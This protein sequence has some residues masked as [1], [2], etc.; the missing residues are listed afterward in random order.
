MK[1]RTT[2]KAF[3]KLVT[4]RLLSGKPISRRY[5]SG[6]GYCLDAL[7]SVIKKQT[8]IHV[9]IATHNKDDYIFNWDADYNMKH[10]FIDNYLNAE[11][12]KHELKRNEVKF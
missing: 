10:M 6:H 5:A 1:K 12:P 7:Y 11:M 4:D 3:F 8:K 2:T 9:R